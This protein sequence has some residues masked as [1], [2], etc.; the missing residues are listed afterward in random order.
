MTRLRLFRVV[1]PVEDLEIATAFYAKVV[2]EPG[3]RVWRNR[4]YFRLGDV[5]LA[6]VQP[7]PE[8]GAFKPESDPRVIYIAVDDLEEIFD[9]I[10]KT[11]A[12]QVDDA[13]G[14]QAWGELSFYAQDPSGNRLC[15]VHEPTVY[16]GGQFEE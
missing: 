3:E 1:I 7:A 5:V 16:T 12:L 4:H 13:I 10:H 6:C 15:F 11:G 14:E 9:R 2:G 8:S